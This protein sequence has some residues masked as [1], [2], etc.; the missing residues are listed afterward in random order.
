[1]NEELS[2]EEYRLKMM[3][4]MVDNI[5]SFIEDKITLM[6]NEENLIAFECG[7]HYLHI[8][9][10]DDNFKFSDILIFDSAFTTIKNAIL[11]SKK[12]GGK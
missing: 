8:Y 12:E 1:M 5:D 11:E 10:V 9:R 6:W 3:R 7:G 4:V 2:D